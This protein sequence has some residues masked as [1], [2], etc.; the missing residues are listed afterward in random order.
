MRKRTVRSGLR[1]V[2][3]ALA[4]IILASFYHGPIA[5]LFSL[6]PPAEERSYQTALYWS[7]LLGGFGVLRIVFGLIRP[8]RK[9]DGD[10]RLL[11]SF[12]AILAALLLFCY[13]VSASL[14]PSDHP[15]HKRLRPGETITI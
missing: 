14:E 1:L 2:A 7:S 13:L 6:S 3:A 11:P 8:A 9:S 5:D 12:L 10:I 4:L 15:R